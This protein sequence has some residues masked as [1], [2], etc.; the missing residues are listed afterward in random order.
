MKK[1]LLT[2]GLAA[3]TLANA[4]AQGTIALNNSVG[5]PVRLDCGDSTSRPATAADG[6][7]IQVW[8]GTGVELSLGG[9]AGVGANGV[10]TGNNLASFQIAGSEAGATVNLQIRAFSSSGIFSA[11]TKVA[12][13][14]L[15][16]TA[17]PGTVIWQGATG[18]NPNRFTPLIICPEPSTLALGGLACALLLFRLRKPTK[19][20]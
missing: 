4:H 11:E 7:V 1:L 2:F 20:N 5:T 16:P 17:G 6:I 18:T 10:I 3:L 8:W 15:G 9:T 14:V 12:Q 19:T 13:V